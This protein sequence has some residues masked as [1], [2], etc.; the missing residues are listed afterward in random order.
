M[1]STDIL[2]SMIAE[3]IAKV[4]LRSARFFG[5]SYSYHVI[6]YANAA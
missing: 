2:K 3:T 6:I 4:C 1:N 5:F